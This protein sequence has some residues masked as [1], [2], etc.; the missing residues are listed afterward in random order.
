MKIRIFLLGLIAIVLVACNGKD[1]SMPATAKDA[2]MKTFEDS[3]SYALGVQMGTSVRRDSIN[4][5]M[6]VYEIG[7]RAGKDSLKLLMPD[8]VMQKVYGK[9]QEKMQQK[10]M[11]KEQE[12]EKLRAEKGK[13]LAQSNVQFLAENKT[14]PGVKVTKSGLQYQILKEG[15]GPNVKKTD[16]ISI[17][18]IAYFA[19]GELFDSL[20]RNQAVDF[21]ASGLFQG[22]DEAV[23]YMK[24]GGKYKF[25]FPPEIAFR[26]RGAGPIPP[27][28]VIIFE[29]EVVGVKDNPVPGGVQIQPAPQQA[30]PQPR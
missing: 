10:Q 9:L 19:N 20:A 29:M 2:G 24:K 6:D 27:N 5:N 22:W 11:A 14:K 18:Y 23:Q 1:S 28:S 16:I 12:A 7:Y 25:V 26:D 30:P 8:S 21:P 4:I 15:T 3:L 17:K 13:M